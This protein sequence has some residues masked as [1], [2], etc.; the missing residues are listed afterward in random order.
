MEP[1]R[2]LPNP[3]G[4]IDQKR[5]TGWRGLSGSHRNIISMYFLPHDTLKAQ[6]IGQEE[7][8]DSMGMYQILSLESEIWIQRLQGKLVGPGGV[9]SRAR[10][11]A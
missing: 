8:I 10:E 5:K 7:D 4:R 6:L 2:P 1:L 3:S 9:Y 11:P